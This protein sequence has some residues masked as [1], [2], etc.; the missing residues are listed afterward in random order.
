M[1]VV[2]L[3][4]LAAVHSYS[5]GC[6]GALKHTLQDYWQAHADAQSAPAAKAVQDN[7]HKE[8]SNKRATR[9]TIHESRFSRIFVDR[10]F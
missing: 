7:G 9:S 4:A 8:T 6:H 3:P 10:C 1:P 2:L 5:S